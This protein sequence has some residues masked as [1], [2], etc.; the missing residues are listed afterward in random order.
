MI[1]NKT[2]L[3]SVAVITY[4]QKEFLRECIESIL[5]QDYPNLEIVISDDASSDGTIEMLI[6][7]KK[8]Y[9]E[10]IVIISA[11]MNQGITKNSNKAHFACT[12]KYVA[13]IG[14]DDLMLPG[15]IS[16]QVEFME[17]HPDCTICYHDLEFFDDHTKK[18]L[19]LKSE[20]FKL[21]DCNTSDIV[22]YGTLNGPCASMVRLSKTPTHG[23]NESLPVASDWLFWVESMLN[24]GKM[25]Y[26][27]AV[28]GR[29]R[30]HDNNIT[31]VS[32]SGVVGQNVIDILN[33]CNIIMSKYPR[34]FKEASIRYSQQLVALRK[35]A[36]YA[37]VLSMSVR[38]RIR[39]KYII[40]LFVYII[41]LGSKKL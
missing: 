14:G 40:A 34:Y 28:L 30:R 39:L 23:F 11:E 27:D 2:P 9:P 24:G 1:G 22:E 41:T 37:S 18:R 21:R 38:I 35:C 15:K 20:K 4:N 32:Q 17:S 33:S 26:L 36:N 5:E 31:N 19:Y 12:G 13:W 8:L 7:Y 10:K 3:V 29:H 6:E 16:K 25:Y